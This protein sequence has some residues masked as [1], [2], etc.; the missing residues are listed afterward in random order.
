M[1]L[2]NSA[3]NLSYTG[4]GLG[5]LSF[6]TAGVRVTMSS[7]TVFTDYEIQA[8]LDG[9]LPAEQEKAVRELIENNE[10]ARNRYQQ[11]KAQKMALK[12]WWITKVKH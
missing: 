6:S 1:L 2:L 8:L 3:N 10:D 12:R 7:E 4:E 5:S 9:A 11:L